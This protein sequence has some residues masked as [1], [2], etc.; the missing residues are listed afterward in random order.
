VN[1]LPN[2]EILR[3][4]FPISGGVFSDSSRSDNVYL[5]APMDFLKD[6]YFSWPIAVKLCTDELAVW[7]LSNYASR[8]YRISEMCTLLGALIEFC[9]HFPFFP[10]TD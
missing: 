10:P 4:N 8:Q 6:F 7:P 1:Y 9:Q 3:K 5:V 2:Y